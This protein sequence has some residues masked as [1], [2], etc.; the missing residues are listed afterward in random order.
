MNYTYNGSSTAPTAAGS[1]A[2]VGT[3]SDINYQ[4]SNTV[5]AGDRQGHARDPLGYSGGDI[6]RDAAERDA[7]QRQLD[8]RRDLCIQPASRNWSDGG[9]RRLCR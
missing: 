7:T 4:G 2:V 5:N 6:L 3:I 8:G 9:S 1:Y